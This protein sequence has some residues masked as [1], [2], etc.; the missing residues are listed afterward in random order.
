M[1]SIRD[2]TPQIDPEKDVLVKLQV[3]VPQSEKRAI[4]A[5]IGDDGAFTFVI[6]TTFQR[7]ATYVRTNNL[8]AGS[9]SDFKLFVEFVRNGTDSRTDRSAD[10]KHDTGTASRL[11]HQNA[12]ASSSP[13]STG[14]SS[15]GRSGKQVG[16]TKSR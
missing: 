1:P 8:T 6:R 9:P 2:L 5:A 14:K 12:S 11:Q 16:K 13:G 15:E 3:W 4:L 10:V 7:L